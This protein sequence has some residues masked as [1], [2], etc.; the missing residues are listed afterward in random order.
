MS[1]NNFSSAKAD[2]FD[3]EYCKSLNKLCND[4]IVLSELK[5]F[6]NRAYDW[7]YESDKLNPDV[8]LVG[9]AIPEE[10]VIA[11]GAAPYW[12]IGGSL[13]STAWSDD[14]VPRDT[15]PVSRS[16]VGYINRPE[17]ADLSDSL[18]IIPL[19]SDSMRKI[20]YDLKSDG[21][22]VCVIDVPPDRNDRYAAEKYTAQLISV[23]E[24]VSKQTKKRVTRSSVASAMKLVS[25]ARIT[26]QKFLQISR[27]CTDIITDS[28]R[29]FVQNSYY[30]SP[31]IDEWVYHTECLISE[32]EHRMNLSKKTASY[33]PAVMLLGSPVLFPNYKIP[34]LI[35]NSGLEISE[36]V[37]SLAMKSFV[38]YPKRV[39]WG[40][41]DRLIKT[42]ALKW[43][44]YDSSSAFVKNDALFD[45]VSWFVQNE[46]VEGVIYHVLKGQI[47]YDFELERFETMLAQYGIPVF[48]LETDYQYQD[49]E[50]L[51]IRLEAFSEMLTQRKYREVK[52]VS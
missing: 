44:I 37:D 33:H 2:N 6:F 32:I 12:I 21:H 20:A 48:R 31:S 10:I 35:S 24:A 29:L 17:C 25:R 5:W 14:L 30:V 51:R 11:A 45:Y 28:A 16:I 3:K 36:T 7:A 23:C 34:F 50:Q 40:R 9:T 41:R 13:G 26:I 15:D 22:K 4:N 42:I 43:L 27:K 46:R 52:K 8:V 49:V 39:L 38:V 18:F 47:E 1:K 19:I